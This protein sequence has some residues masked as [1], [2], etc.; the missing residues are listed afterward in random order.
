MKKTVWFGIGLSGAIIFGAAGST[1][2]QTAQ[3]AD[4]NRA[5]QEQINQLQQTLNAIKS[6]Q[7]DAAAETA[8][9]GATPSSEPAPSAPA[10]ATH[11]ATPG[12]CFLHPNPGA[13]V[14]LLTP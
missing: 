9:T 8:Q 5:L 3:V 11:W 2:A 14:P 4:Q 12:P 6:T 13:P 10:P 1:N 7:P